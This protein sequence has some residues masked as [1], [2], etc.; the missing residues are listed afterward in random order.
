[1]NR[2]YTFLASAFFSATVTGQAPAGSNH[3]AVLRDEKPCVAFSFDDGRTD[4]MVNYKGEV[5]NDMIIN[6]LKQYKI[7]TIMFVIGKRLDDDKG[8]AF[9]QKWNDAGNYIGNHTYNHVNYNNSLMT[10]VDYI[11]EIQK[12]DSLINRYENYRKIFRFPMLK[13]GNTIAKRDSICSYL[14]Q[15]GY[16]QG[17]VTIDNSDWYICNRLLKRLKENPQADLTGFRDFYVNHIFERA[18]Y[19]NELSKEINHRQ[20]K[21]TLLLHINLTSALFLSDLIE[22]FQKEGWIIE[23]Y[24]S[25][26]KD[27]IYD[28]IP[29]TM[30][31]DQSLIWSLAKKTGQYDDKLRYPGEDG[32]YEKEKMDKL[33]L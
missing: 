6:Q 13:A 22:K 15:N 11:K 27:P 30:P 23:D 9:L 32:E 5:W 8:K 14:K 33:G 7:Q 20:I 29:S 17:W 31:S 12:C 3:Q 28:E 26:I 25:A 24:S 16:R 1:M 21:H 10:C 2:L 18:Q 4:D 19:Y